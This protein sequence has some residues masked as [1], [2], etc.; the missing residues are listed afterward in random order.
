MMTFTRDFAGATHRGNIF[1]RET[2]ATSLSANYVTSFT[3]TQKIRLVRHWA[4]LLVPKKPIIS[5]TTVYRRDKVDHTEK[6]YPSYE[7]LRFPNQAE[8][9]GKC[10]G[11]PIFRRQHLLPGADVLKTRRS[12]DHWLS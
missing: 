6:K 7:I 1:W 11:H 12:I 5:L 3:S 2:H 10:R 8:H 4:E 9:F